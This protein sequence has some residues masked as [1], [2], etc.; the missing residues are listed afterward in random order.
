MTIYVIYIVTDTFHF[1]K[2]H[3][4]S[5]HAYEKRTSQI[6]LISYHLSYDTNLQLSIS[7]RPTPQL[8]HIPSQNC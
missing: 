4:C 2:Y 7:L 3:I 6:L 8:Y 1:K 5:C